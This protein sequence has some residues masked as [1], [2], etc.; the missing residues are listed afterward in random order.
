MAQRKKTHNF[1]TRDSEELEFGPPIEFVLGDRTW[2]VVP[3]KVPAG[4][5]MGLFSAFVEGENTGTVVHFYNSMI[6]FFMYLL[7]PEEGTEF[8]R[9][10]NGVDV[11]EDKIVDVGLALEVGQWVLEQ[12]SERPT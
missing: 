8:V 1:D 3:K 11:P 5:T 2:T 9:M 12:I 10:L 4:I 6:K 7:G